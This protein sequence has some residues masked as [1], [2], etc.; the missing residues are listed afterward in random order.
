M[1]AVLADGADPRQA[2]GSL[3]EHDVFFEGERALEHHVVAMRHDFLP[4][5]FAGRRQRRLGE[6]EV[7]ALVVGADQ[8]AAAL[9]IDLVFVI[10]PPRRQHAEQGERCRRVEDV[11]LGGRVRSRDEHQESGASGT[12]DLEIEALVFFFEDQNGLAVGESFHA[13]ETRGAFRVVLLGEEDRARIGRPRDRDGLLERPVPEGSRRQILD[14]ETVLTKSGVVRRVRETPSVVTHHV[15]AERHE[16]LALSER[17]HV[18]NRFERRVRDPRETP[19][20]D[21][22]LRTLDRSNPVFV[23]PEEIRRRDIVLLDPREHLVVQRR[24]QPGERRHHA[25]GMAILGFEIL[26]NFRIRFFSQPEVG[27]LEGVAMNGDGVR[28]ALRDWGLRLGH[29]ERLARSR[30]FVEVRIRAQALASSFVKSGTSRVYSSAMR[31][32]DRMKSAVARL[33][34]IGVLY[35]TAIRSSAFT[36]TS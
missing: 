8:E 15:R 19:L 25:V 18:E 20:V 16:R 2:A 6:A 32:L 9:V 22:V 23:S 13:I 10:L 30:L 28:H 14:V 4:V 24:G 17:V 34:A 3:T 27:V 11:K 33:Q 31:W 1:R 29:P 36:S 35:T 12:E 21:R 5:F 26:A 7:A